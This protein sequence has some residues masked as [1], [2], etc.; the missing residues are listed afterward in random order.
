MLDFPTHQ[1]KDQIQTTHD[2]PFGEIILNTSDEQRLKD[3]AIAIFNAGVQAVDP[4]VCLQRHLRLVGDRLGIGREEYSL[5]K[6]E[7][8]YVAGVPMGS[9]LYF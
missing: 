1:P 8:L 9:H 6:V 4:Q 5:T 3:I 2:H 7:K